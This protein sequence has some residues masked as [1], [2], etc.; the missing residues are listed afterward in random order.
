[1]ELQ[2]DLKLR[3]GIIATCGALLANEVCFFIRE[4]GLDN[5]LATSL[6]KMILYVFIICITYSKSFSQ[7]LDK[8]QAVLDRILDEVHAQRGIPQRFRNFSN[9]FPSKD[10]VNSQ[11]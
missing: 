2:S 1:M 5:P 4:K 3:F 7:S 6:F 10:E 8:I 9:S 11:N